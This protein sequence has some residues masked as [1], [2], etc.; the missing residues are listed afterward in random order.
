MTRSDRLRPVQPDVSIILPAYNEA[1]ALPSVLADIA[2]TVRSSHEVLVVDDASTD[3]TARVARGAGATV[4]TH[5]RNRGKGAAMVTGAEAARS[6]RLVFMDADGT[7]PP[8]AID[9]LVSLLD[10]HQV[11]R[12]TRT[13]GP[14]NTPWLNRLG[15]TFFDRLLG[16]F[17]RLPGVD[18]LSGLYAIRRQEFLDMRLE[19]RGFDVEVEIGIKSR[20][21]GL[22]VA[23]HPIEYRP[24]IGEKK[25]RPLADG[26]HILTRMIGMLLLFSPVA[27]FVVPGL[28]LILGGLML[29]LALWNGPLRLASLGLSGHSFIVASLGLVGG[30]QLLIIGTAAALY[31]TEAGFPA[32]SWLVA[33]SRRPI[34]ITLA[35]LGAITAGAGAVGTIIRVVR[36]VARG[37]GVFNDTVPLVGWATLGLVG[38]ELLAAG[39]FLSIFEGRLRD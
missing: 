16:A 35:G 37:G 15:N 10:E 8:Q 28:V 29:A 7:Y 22:S 36:W 31:R 1:E 34:R 11:A 30:I 13:I 23:S 2:R 3:D 26:L 24:R 33:A 39:L 20:M 25:L 38:L 4:I 12:G 6:D 21:M 17:H 5:E 27:T 32:R 19:S 18:H 9:R 14:A